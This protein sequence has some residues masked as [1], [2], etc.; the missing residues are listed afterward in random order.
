MIKFLKNTKS[1]SCARVR[2]RKATERA[3]LLAA[4]QLFAKK[5]Y[6]NTRTLEIAKAAGA[7]EALIL[8]Y[9][10]GKEGLL[11]SLLKDEEALQIIVSEHGDSVCSDLEAMPIVIGKHGLKGALLE[12][13][14]NAQSIIQVKCPFMKIAS[15]RALVDTE[16]ASIVR[17][18]L[19]DRQLQILSSRLK[20]LIEGQK[21]K[22]T[23]RQ[24]E[25]ITLILGSANYMLNFMLR[26]V[27]EMEPERIDHA[28]ELLA[29]VLDRYITDE[30]VS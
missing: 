5:G 25:G 6:E 2:D 30:M 19:M 20:K 23:P 29:E 17:D 1:H 3:F 11:V 15:S 21:G 16:M 7:N 27:Y 24:L 28:L 8:R 14:K 10:G 26:E 22:V 13:F 4:A 18:R 9:F 12:F